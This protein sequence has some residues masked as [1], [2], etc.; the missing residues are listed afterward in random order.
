MRQRWTKRF[1]R[2]KP[3]EWISRLEKFGAKYRAGLAGEM[4]T[5]WDRRHAIVHAPPAA[6]SDHVTGLSKSAVARYVQ[7][8]TG[9]KDAISVIFSFVESTDAFV[10]GVINAKRSSCETRTESR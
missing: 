6:R 8:K 2:G 4:K 1:L 9:F 3:G 10:V 5:V 7:S